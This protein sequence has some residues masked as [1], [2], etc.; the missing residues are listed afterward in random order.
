MKI[1]LYS[2]YRVTLAS[3]YLLDTTA[4]DYR[5]AL[6]STMTDYEDAVMVETALH[7]GCDCIVTRNLKDYKNASIPSY[8]PSDFLQHITPTEV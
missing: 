8:S 7:S 4:M 3:Q 1:A 2:A 5:R 6:S